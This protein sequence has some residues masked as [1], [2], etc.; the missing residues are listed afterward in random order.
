MTTTTSTDKPQSVVMYSV[1]YTGG[2]EVGGTK[3]FLSRPDAQAHADRLWRH[4]KTR[5][6]SRSQRAERIGADY[7]AVPRITD[8]Q[9]YSKPT[10]GEVTLTPDS[11]MAFF[12]F[13]DDL[14]RSWWQWWVGA[15]INGKLIQPSEPTSRPATA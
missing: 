12:T 9:P 5:N 1:S 15:T 8:V 13:G 14:T 7:D 10:L 4:N 3:L 11:L 6:R 2:L